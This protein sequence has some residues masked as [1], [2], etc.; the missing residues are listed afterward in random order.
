MNHHRNQWWPS[1]LAVTC[2]TRPQWVNS[3]ASERCGS[4]LSIFFKLIMQNNILG[5]R[6]NIVLRW[7]P[8]DLTDD[9]STL[10]QVMGWY[11]QATSHYLRQY[12]SRSLSPYGITRPQWVDIKMSLMCK[13]N[14]S[15]EFNSVSEYANLTVSVNMMPTFFCMAR[16]D[17]ESY[18][19]GLVQERCNSSA[20]AMELRLSCTNPSIYTFS[21]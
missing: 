16:S 1:S 13:T 20:L 17:I 6:C 10:V 8:Q 3:L 7:M 18:I 9:E 19:D 5:T 11:R 4:N 21:S 2:V 12:W 15:S 14:L